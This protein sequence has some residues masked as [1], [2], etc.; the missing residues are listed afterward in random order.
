MVQHI[1]KTDVFKNE[2]KNTT[3]ETLHCE[4]KAVIHCY[5]VDDLRLC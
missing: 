4:N 5:M 2:S 3:F 1:D